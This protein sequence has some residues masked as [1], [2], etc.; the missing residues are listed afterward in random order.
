MGREVE[1]AEIRGLLDK[2]RLVTLVGA[3]GVGK[4]RLAL[5][6]A[7]QV[8]DRYADGARFVDLSVVCEPTLLVQ[9]VASVLSVPQRTDQDPLRTL[10][11]HLS[12]KSLLLVLD[13]CEHLLDACADFVCRIAPTCG[14]V[15]ILATSRQEL[16]IVGE[17]PWRVP[18][19]TLPNS[20]AFPD[21]ST[22]EA[23]GL[24]LSRVPEGMDLSSSTVGPVSRIC[25]R[26][27][28]I[29]LALELAAGRV[30]E[31]TIEEVEAKLD[32]R[33]ELLKTAQRGISERHRT[34]RAA[35][36]W[37]HDLLP[38]PERVLLRRLS[39]FAGPFTPDAAAQVVGVRRIG[40]EGAD[41]HV[42]RLARKSLL[43][44]QIDDGQTRYRYHESIHNFVREKLQAAGEMEA[45]RF[46][47]FQWCVRL[48]T[49]TDDP[50]AEV[51]QVQSMANLATCY[52]ELP[53][54]LAWSMDHNPDLGIELAGN[55]TRFWV[56]R[57][58]LG[59][60]GR[61]L[62]LALAS[63]EGAPVTR[64][65]A[66][67]GAGLVACLT[68]NFADVRS[69]VEEGLELARQSDD[70]GTQARLLNLQGVTRIFTDPSSAIEVLSEAIALAREDDD[71]VTLVSSLAMKGFAQ[72]VGG[73]LDAAFDALEECLNRSSFLSESQPLIMG[74]VGLGHVCVHQANPKRALHLLDDGMTRARQVGN[75]IWLAL[76]LVFR[77][78][79]S[80]Y[81][82][83][84][85]GARERAKAAVDVARNTMS[86]PVV[87]LC[88]ALAGTIE[89]DVGEPAAS[90]P[91]LAEALGCCKTG[92]RGGVRP[93]ALVGLGR[94]RL[95]LGDPEA[96]E[97]LLE[98]A[99]AVAT[100]G[101]NRSAAAA[102]LYWL[103]H[104]ASERG[105]HQA[106][107]GMYREALTLER[108]AGHH[109]AIPGLIE[110]VAAEVAH[111]GE[112]SK[113]SCLLGAADSL[114]GDRGLIRSSKDIASCGV[115]HLLA[116]QTLGPQKRKAAVMAGTLLPPDRVV[117]YACGGRG[118]HKRPGFGW[119]SLTPTELRVV[120]LVAEH[121]TN[122]EIG[123]RLLMAP[124]T[125]KTH[126]SHVYRKLDLRSRRELAH[127]VLRRAHVSDDE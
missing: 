45:V 95:E 10:T 73:R 112:T 14:N 19:L 11:V 125:V 116:D 53:A 105:D 122:V 2:S 17:I 68:G 44:R 26:L 78:E 9:A 101:G 7:A 12:D 81:L 82:G 118:L 25:R 123:Q 52:A 56:S 62:A 39:V 31:F 94:A 57:G 124:G 72:A 85:K 77:S 114:R 43:I 109:L 64:A 74:L 120:D 103:A 16:S 70:A 15:T 22:S 42:A 75:P 126:L 24:F 100:K 61:W 3:P 84:F 99:M 33:F 98:D 106:A 54:A 30:G 117:S 36:E 86:P 18:V 67:W 92:E 1:V 83:D 71:P 27:D 121:L 108:Q 32:H 47:H 69:A 107:L 91:L 37:S 41:T 48:A 8:L 119:L 20:D 21:V 96:A 66:L 90:I 46:A 63:G 29:P 49:Q 93:R 104:L 97:S 13:N 89:L 115:V 76:A 5:H 28:G 113:A 50:S 34:L 40:G 60:A 88:L 55:L 79:L 4:T 111:M 23:A 65:K 110:A 51:D 38:E 127:E 80:A 6:T 58:F 102:A 35:L 87:G 59:E